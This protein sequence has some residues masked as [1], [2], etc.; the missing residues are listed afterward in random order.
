VGLVEALP[1]GTVALDTVSFIYYI[2]DHPRFAEVLDPLF[3]SADAG[4]RRIV[5]SALTLLEVLVIPFRTGR[6][7]LAARYEAI[8][9]GSRGLTLVDIDRPHLRAAAQLR[10]SRRVRTP[11][12]LQ[13]VTALNQ[14]CTAFVTNDRR[15]PDIPG[16]AIV[17]LSDVA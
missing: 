3:R 12:A 16:L 17:Q 11:D 5:T 10:A 13:L 1:P 7:D 4:G 6:L 15:L 14:R 9:T 2:E 8:L